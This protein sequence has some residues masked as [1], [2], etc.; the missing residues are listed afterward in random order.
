M[1]Q[2]RLPSNYERGASSNLETDT[3]N[4]EKKRRGFDVTARG[5][6][7]LDHVR[8]SSPAPWRSEDQALI[9]RLVA[10]DEEAYEVLVRLHGGRLFACARR[11]LRDEQDAKDAVQ[12]AFVSVHKHI[13][14]FTG[15]A[16]LGAWLRRIVINHALMKLRCRKRQREECID[17]FLPTFDAAGAHERT[18]HTWQESTDR[19]MERNQTRRMVRAMIDRLPESHRTALMLRDIEELS[20]REAARV[21]GVSETAMKVRLHRARQALRTL[22]LEARLAVDEE[23]R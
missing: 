17:T 13:C 16:P 9:D 7:R 19:L 3:A 23:T 11:L 4:P 2:H 1:V 5:H 18:P 8:E 10:G 12:E 22:L 21:L 6:T 20:T 15:N 14:T